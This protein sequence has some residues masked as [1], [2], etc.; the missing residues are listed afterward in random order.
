MKN[1]CVLRHQGDVVLMQK[2]A[3]IEQA[4]LKLMGFVFF[5]YASVLYSLPTSAA[6]SPV[7]TERTLHGIVLSRKQL[8]QI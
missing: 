7:I 2:K 8:L 6:H 1:D 4:C 5:I 3:M